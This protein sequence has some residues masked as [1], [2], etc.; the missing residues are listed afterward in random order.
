MAGVASLA[1]GAYAPATDGALLVDEVAEASPSDTERVGQEFLKTT[2]D[3]WFLLSGIR[4]K[5]EADKAAP[6]FLELVQRIAELDELLS[7]LPMVPTADVQEE[8]SE[9]VHVVGMMDGVH[10]RILEAFE[11]LN[12]EFLGLCRVRCYGSVRL[13]VAFRQAVASGMFNEDD[14]EL[15][16]TPPAPLDEKEM[17]H[18]LVR[19]KRLLV[20]DRA[21][22]E[23]L[24]LVKDED[25]AREAVTRLRELT[26]RLQALIAYCRERGIKVCNVVNYSTAMV[27]QHILFR[28]VV[29]ST[30]TL[31]RLQMQHCR[32]PSLRWSH[33]CGESEVKLCGLP[34]F[35][36]IIRNRLMVFL[37]PW[38]RCS[39]AWER[40]TVS[41]LKACLMHRSVLIWRKPLAKI[42]PIQIK[43]PYST[44]HHACFRL[45]RYHR[46]GGSL[47]D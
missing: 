33:Y 20:P 46:T 24:E 16:Q 8:D 41:V 34:L 22:L 18:E 32:T 15:L 27:A 25:S 19:L 11:D 12:A 17:R 23:T 38:I 47:P 26:V 39:R 45:S 13:R 28:K 37:M 14:V 31:L 4:D 44:I 10:L 1:L 6:R 35:P 30:E 5:E 29:Y 43:S 21:L 9:T 7:H 40:R 3:M 42:Q 36:A 2:S